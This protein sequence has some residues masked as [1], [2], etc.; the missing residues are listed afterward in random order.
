MRT[1]HRRL[2]RIGASTLLAMVL[3]AGAQAHHSGAMFDDRRETT[4]TGT[5]RE[6]QWTSPH[7][8]IQL[9]VKDGKG[10][11]EEWSLE[12]GAPVYL[13]RLGWRQHSL[14]P[15]NT[16]I[17]KVLPLR[18]GQKGALVQEITHAD[19]SPIGKAGQ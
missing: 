4:L 17:A 16:V 13:Y 8:Y 6:F 12:M 2:Q 14:V 10:G 9:L 7:C 1:M 18:N 19:G 11:E 5:V 15:G 3:V